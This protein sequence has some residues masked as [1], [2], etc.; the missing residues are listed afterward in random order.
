MSL[1]LNMSADQAV[2]SRPDSCHVYANGTQVPGHVC[3]L[4]GPESYRQ[5]LSPWTVKATWSGTGPAFYEPER[6]DAPPGGIQVV[7]FDA[8]GRPMAWWDSTRDTSRFDWA[9]E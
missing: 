4:D 6:K 2:P 1:E 5:P 8:N 7:A 3:R 9:I